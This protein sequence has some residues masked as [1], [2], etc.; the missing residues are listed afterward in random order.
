MLDLPKPELK[1]PKDVIIAVH[2]GSVNPIDVKYAG[3]AMKMVVSDSYVFASVPIAKSLNI[4]R[5]PSPIGFDCAGTVTEVGSD[6]TRCKVGDEVYTRLPGS[7]RGLFCVLYAVSS[8][9]ER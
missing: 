4:P 6:V 2:A 8:D 1:D 9:R 7:C 5:F 3:G